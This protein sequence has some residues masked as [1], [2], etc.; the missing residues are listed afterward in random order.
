VADYVHFEN[1]DLNGRLTVGRGAM[2]ILEK[3]VTLV[4]D[5]TRTAFTGDTAIYA[6]EDSFVKIGR[7]ID[8]EGTVVIGNATLN[9]YGDGINVSSMIVV[10]GGS[11]EAASE[12][13]PGTGNV[14]AGVTTPNFI[15]VNG[16]V[17]NLKDGAF[18]FQSLSVNGAFV[19]ISTIGSTP[20]TS[21][22]T[23]GI[24]VTKGTLILKGLTSLKFNEITPVVGNG[25][26]MLRDNSSATISIDQDTSFPALETS[27]SSY[28]RLGPLNSSKFTVQ[29][30]Y[31]GWGSSI[32]S[33]DSTSGASN[34]V[35]ENSIVAS[36]NS[37]IQWGVVDVS[38]PPSTLT[39]ENGC[40]DN[41][42]GNDLC[43][44]IAD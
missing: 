7:N 17:V 31:V 33:N 15:A 27:Y 35:V 32:T 19:S 3:N 14:L 16:A 30:L 44:L 8:I 10:N 22:E 18:N 43:D 23:G 39:I 5:P 36:H 9:M 4:S 6:T 21:L 20:V 24:S 26:I 28:L 1:I 13:V 40:A 42:L 2:V 12:F 34:I 37:F 38:S 41:G 29:D 11:V 25:G